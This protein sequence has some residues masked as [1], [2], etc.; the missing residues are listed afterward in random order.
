MWEIQL[1]EYRLDFFDCR[2]QPWYLQA[3]AY[4]KE[5]IIL[6]DKSGSMK[7]RSDI[8]SNATAVEI[9]NTLTDNDYFNVMLFSDITIYADPMITDRLIQATKFNKDKMIKNFRKFSPNGTASYENA[10]TEVFTLFNKTDEKSPTNLKCNRMIMIITD[11]AP[12]SYEYLFKE[13]NPQKNVRVFTYLL[14]QHSSA[15]EYVEELA[16]LNRVGRLVSD[17]VTSEVV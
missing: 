10:I 5:M 6:I 16:C 7:G 11:N 17:G 15:E 3:S 9:L 2:S 14:G 12:G 4:P 13:F 1:D 8:L